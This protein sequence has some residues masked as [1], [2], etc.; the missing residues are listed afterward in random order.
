MGLSI[1]TGKVSINENYKIKIYFYIKKNC[2]NY[3]RYYT[4]NSG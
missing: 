2:L 4:V 3:K 1:T